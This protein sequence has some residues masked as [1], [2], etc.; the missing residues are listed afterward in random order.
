MKH[1]F[2]VPGED[3]RGRRKYVKPALALAFLLASL[4][5]GNAWAQHGGHGSHPGFHGH[6]G[7]HV[8][9]GA[10]LF[11][12][13]TAWY[14]FD[15]YPYSRPLPP[16]I[17]VERSGDAGPQ[18]YYCSKPAGYYPYVK[19]CTTTWRVVAPPPAPQ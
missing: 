9:L 7:G 13:G 11:W 6:H 19:Q 4:A 2:S 5:C 8:V 18:W 3:G 17:Y 15:D 12:Y 10:P 14:A 16:P 1:R